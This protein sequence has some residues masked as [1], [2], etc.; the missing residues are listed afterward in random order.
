MS[1]RS[2]FSR[3]WRSRFSRSWRSRTRSW[4]RWIGRARRFFCGRRR[5]WSRMGSRSRLCRSCGRSWLRGRCRL[6]AFRGYRSRT[7][8]SR[9]RFYRLG[10]RWRDLHRR[11]HRRRWAQGSQ[12]SSGQWLAG[13]GSHGGLFLLE[14]YGRRGRSLLCD[15]LPAHHRRGRGGDVSRG[16]S[17]AAQHAVAGWIY[18]HVR[19]HRSSR[20]LLRRDSHG[21]FSNGL[22]TRERVLRDGHDGARH[23]A[24]GISDVGDGRGLVDDGCVVNHRHLRD[25]HGGAADVNLRHVSLAD[26]VCR[27]VDFTRAQR[28][29]A[30]VSAP[31]TTATNKNYERWCVDWRLRRR[32]SDP[33]PAARGKDPTSIV[34]RR[35]AP[36]SII[37]PGVAPGIDPGPVARVI[38]RPAVFDTVGKPYMPIHGII[39]PIAVVIEVFVSHHIGRQILRG[40]RVVVTVIA[41][42]DPHVEP[43]GLVDWFYIGVQIARPVKV[44]DLSGLHG[45]SLPAACHVPIASP[46]TNDGQAAILGHLH[47][48]ASRVGDIESEIRGVDFEI[49]VAAQTAHADVNCSGT[50]LQLHGVVIEI[51]KGNAGVLGQANGGRTELQFGARFSVGPK[52]VACRHR[53]IWN[54]PDPVTGSGRLKG[55]RS[56]EVAKTSHSGGRIILCVY[57]CGKHNRD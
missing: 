27:D 52:L 30:H 40:P 57:C 18:S 50:Q 47:A 42:L 16:R 24:V 54:C 38:R 43:I 49:V 31:A 13:M 9:W 35:I 20:D 6:S 26:G 56:F 17:S 14:R 3:S 7:W 53:P 37:D 1:R 41:A 5:R 25:I 29:P 12:L 8:V 46:D 10:S 15:Y 21:N 2:R 22:P 32:T 34:E 11:P 48:I 55:N 39:L 33:T 51:Q 23:A 28:E 44:A 45:V 4:S 36:R 19:S